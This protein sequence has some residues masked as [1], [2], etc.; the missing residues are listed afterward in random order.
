M[1]LQVSILYIPAT[2]LNAKTS[3]SFVPDI[4]FIKLGEKDSVAVRVV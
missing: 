2:S 4:L 3:I 1:A